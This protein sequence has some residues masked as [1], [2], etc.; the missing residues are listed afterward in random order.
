MSAPT[1]FTADELRQMRLRV[2]N[3]QAAGDPWPAE[4]GWDRWFATLEE[5]VGHMAEAAA[6]AIARAAKR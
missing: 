5:A 1:P 6:V 3:A 4:A 2:D